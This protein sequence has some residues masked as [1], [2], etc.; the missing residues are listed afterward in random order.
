MQTHSRNFRLELKGITSPKE[1]LLPAQYPSIGKCRHP[2]TT[3]TNPL[4][5][6]ENIFPQRPQL[7]LQIESAPDI[8]LRCGFWEFFCPLSTGRPLS[9]TDRPT[10]KTLA[11][12]RNRLTN[13][14]IRGILRI[15]IINTG[16][17]KLANLIKRE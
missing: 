12:P 13:P 3:H 1:G 17:L 14:P 11:K 15:A 16:V 4:L 6:V 2:Q 5:K 9:E 7:P 10:P 8:P